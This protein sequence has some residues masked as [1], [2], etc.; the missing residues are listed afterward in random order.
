MKTLFQAK[1]KEEEQQRAVADHRRGV[2]A[3]GMDVSTGQPTQDL[4]DDSNRVKTA[5]ETIKDEEIERLR[6]QCAKLQDRCNALEGQNALLNNFSEQNLRIMGDTQQQMSQNIDQYALKFQQ[7]S[8]SEKEEILEAAQE[9]IKTLNEM[10]EH[11]KSQLGIKERQ[12][13]KLRDELLQ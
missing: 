4:L 2:R 12:I 5:A 1:L 9:T 7:V 3:G 11:K 6:E 8:R 13:E 10:L